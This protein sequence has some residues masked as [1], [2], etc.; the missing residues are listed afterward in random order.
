MWPELVMKILQGGLD[1]DF[2]K[3]ICGE[4]SQLGPPETYL[5]VTHVATLQLSYMRVLQMSHLLLYESSTD[6]RDA[7]WAASYGQHGQLVM[8]VRETHMTVSQQGAQGHTTY[9]RRCEQRAPDGKFVMTHIQ[10][11]EEP[12]YLCMQFLRRSENIVQIKASPLRPNRSLELCEDRHMTT[13]RWPIVHMS[14]TPDH[15]IPCPLQGGYNLRLFHPNDSMLCPD[16]TL[17]LR[18]ESDCEQGEGIMLDFRQ[19]ECVPAMLPQAVR[20]QVFCIAHWT[21]GSHN[22]IV[23]QHAN[24]HKQTWCLRVTGPLLHLRHA[25]LLLDLVCDTSDVIKDTSN[26]YRLQLSRRVYASTCEDDI[27]KEVCQN[28]KHLCMTHLKRHCARTCGVCGKERGGDCAF[29][30]TYRGLWVDSTRTHDRQLNVGAYSMHLQHLGSYDCLRL[31]DTK[32]H[33]DKRVLVRIDENGC[34][35]RYACAEMEKV[36]SSV[37]RFRLGNRLQWPLPH[38]RDH[39]DHVCAKENF[40]SRDTLESQFHEPRAPRLLVKAANI[41]RVSCDLPK[42]LH[43]GIAFREEEQSCSGCLLYQ[44]S[45]SR[46]RFVI[47]PHNCSLTQ[48]RRAQP[49]VTPRQHHVTST[50]F[51]CVA[52]FT[53]QNHSHAVVTTSAAFTLLGQYLAWIFTPDG[54]LQVLKAGD[55]LQLKAEDLMNLELLEAQFTVV[56]NNRDADHDCRLRHRHHFSHTH[57]SS[58]SSR[59]HDRHPPT[60]TRPG[61]NGSGSSQA[62]NATRLP[63]VAVT[64]RVDVNFRK[65]AGSG[66][67]LGPESGGVE[68]WGEEEGGRRGAGDS[69]EGALSGSSRLLETSSSSCFVMVAVAAVVHPLL[70]TTLMLSHTSPL[71]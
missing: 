44:P 64:Y 68:G 15:N 9:T 26:F 61:Q 16:S 6:Q 34:Y 5:L 47:R 60:P 54:H 51:S 33:K 69:K 27:A 62:Q 32:K 20:Q 65:A 30:E 36:S 10:K 66:A 21:Q 40:R 25:H 29:E 46:D 59:P 1:S 56:T 43:H 45:V 41:N 70:V 11:G 55:L 23:L 13:D 58:S 63:P 14:Q 18:L 4:R 7:P 22:F 42:A 19:P 57:T 31:Q 12:S 50:E 37:M 8:Y 17:L 71:R 53:L 24:V 49:A 38:V 52:T 2:R 67:V 39:K 48:R 3:G 28:M 35:P